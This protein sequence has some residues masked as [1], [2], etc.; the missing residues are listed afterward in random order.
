MQSLATAWNKLLR[1]ASNTTIAGKKILCAYNALVDCQV[2]L[3]RKQLAEAARKASF[4]PT[5]PA[6]VT[7]DEELAN[8]LM[9]CFAQGKA[10]HK[11]TT[12]EF[13]STLPKKFPRHARKLGGQAGIISSQ[14]S[15]LGATTVLYTPNRPLETFKLLHEKVL[16]PT[17]TT[18]GE[19]VLESARNACRKSDPQK[20]NW[21]LEFSK[22]Q[23]VRAHDRIVSCPRSNRLILATPFPGTP[24][25]DE[26]TMKVLPQLGKKI[27]CVVLAG[28]HYLLPKYDN[29]KTFDYYVKL[30]ERAIKALKKGNRRLRAH[31]EFVPFPCQEIQESVVKHA[32]KNFDSLGLNE[33]EALQL[34][35]KAS[36]G[37]PKQE[38]ASLLYESAL[39]ILRETRI[40]RVHVHAPG[41][42]VIVLRKPCAVPPE[43]ARNAALFASLAAT[44]KARVGRE[45]SAAEMQ[46]TTRKP[47]SARG[48]KQ[49]IEF[50]T[51][52]KLPKKFCL[53]GIAEF[54]DH[55]ALV[56]PSQFQ[57]KSNGTVG[58]GDVL[59]GCAFA[60]ETPA[61]AP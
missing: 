34:A 43:K 35:G 55:Y 61:S 56:I 25:F 2:F 41:L 20:T 37:T 32:T 52:N 9:L 33:V 18:N 13:A 38:S 6:K 14:L 49:L 3:S 21:I 26:E 31:L 57:E 48:L 16:F 47:V 45:F 5:E 53:E 24:S 7:S 30:E 60:A 29:G 44:T 1:K 10:G 12:N 23:S 17:T 50:A 8:E 15:R 36:H 58:L 28:H 4:P 51:E 27:D 40:Q 54:G 39:A 59:S 46:A 11:P 19:L 22:G 42:Q